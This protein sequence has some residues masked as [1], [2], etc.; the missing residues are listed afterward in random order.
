MMRYL[1]TLPLLAGV[2]LTACATMVSETSQTI[3][4]A[5]AYD[6]ASVFAKD[7]RPAEDFEQYKIRHARDVLTFTGVRPGMTVVELKARSGMYT[8]LFSRIVGEEGKVY[9]Q[10]PPEFDTFLGDAV[11][12]RMDGRL[13]NVTHLKVAFDDLMAVADDEV[14]LVTWFLGPHELWYT[15]PGAET[16]VLGD[17]GGTFA[18]IARVLKS[19]G[20]FIVL[21][22]MAPVGAPATTGGETHRIDKAIVIDMARTAGLKLVAESDMLANPRDDRKIM[23]SDPA[24]RH[25]TDRFLLK[26]RKP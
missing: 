26:F 23:A 14:D 19:G 1:N 24:V 3:A 4:P 10:N 13:R 21:D 25:K 20:Q 17:P 12:Q 9:L 2:A 15:P 18:E 8:E 16:G 22:H 7:D 6:Y 11:E 5:P